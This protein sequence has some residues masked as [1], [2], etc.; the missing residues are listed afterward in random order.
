MMFG[1]LLKAIETDISSTT[2]HCHTCNTL[3]EMQER[4]ELC[5]DILH[6]RSPYGVTLTWAFALSA[7]FML[8]PANLLPIMLVYTY[9]GVEGGNI[10]SG[11]MYFIET[12]VYYI[13]FIIFFFSIVVPIFKLAVLYYMLYLIHFKKQINSKRR[14][15]LFNFI[16]YI[17]KWSILD[18]FVVGIMIALVQFESLGH[19][20]AG[21]G[22]TSF[23]AVV[24]L[25]MFATFSFDIRYIWDIQT[26]TPQKQREGNG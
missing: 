8:I 9:E 17:G 5:G 19:V 2:I 13:A 21:Y 24:L 10:M 7:T 1:G 3:N 16:H 15:K 22:I 25:T 20:I 6:Q 18:I 12:K 26:D 4:C 23:A 11:V 14:M